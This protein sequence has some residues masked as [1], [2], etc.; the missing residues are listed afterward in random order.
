MLNGRI[1]DPPVARADLA[2]GRIVDPPVAG[3]DSIRAE[4]NLPKPRKPRNDDDEHQE[5]PYYSS[6]ASHLQGR[7]HKQ[8][9]SEERASLPS[10][11]SLA[12]LDIN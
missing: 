7:N 9:Q 6:V 11:G 12:D 3:T 4:K 1:V 8:K 5:P 10:L 2:Y